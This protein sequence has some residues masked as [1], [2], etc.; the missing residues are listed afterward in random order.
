[1]P[2]S[3]KRSTDSLLERARRGSKSALNRLMASCRPW[4]RRKAKAGLAR[5][6]RCFGRRPEVS[7][8]GHPARFGEFKGHKLLDSTAGWGLSSRI[9]SSASTSLLGTEK[10]GPQA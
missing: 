1:M 5:R 2:S 4:L 3:E 10:A 9:S 7:V 8:D 6:A